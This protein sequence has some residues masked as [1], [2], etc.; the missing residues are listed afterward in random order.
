MSAYPKC[1]AHILVLHAIT[2]CDTTSAI[3]KRGKTAILKMFE[4]KNDL[5][6]CPQA[7]KKIDSS[8]HDMTNGIKLPLGIYAAPKKNV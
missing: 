8:P 6:D 4:K 7:F 5:I 2:G 1:E 3:F